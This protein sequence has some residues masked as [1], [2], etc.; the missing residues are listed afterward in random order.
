MA[1]P[2]LPPYVGDEKAGRRHSL[3]CSLTQLARQREGHPACIGVPEAAMWLELCTSSTAIFSISSSMKIQN[4]STFCY[5]E[6]VAV[7]RVWPLWAWPKHFLGQC[8]IRIHCVWRLILGR[9][10]Q[11]VKKGER[12]TVPVWI[13]D[14]PKNLGLMT[15]GGLTLPESTPS[16]CTLL[17]VQIPLIV[18]LFL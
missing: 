15:S 1:T 6:S 16:E 14:K 17:S 11:L 12:R 13:S 18:E 9:V 8:G 10:V 7:S 5:S 3:P 4:G 2:H